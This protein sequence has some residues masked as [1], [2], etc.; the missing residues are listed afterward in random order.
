M[1]QRGSGTRPWVSSG[2]GAKCVWGTQ[3]RVGDPACP[4]NPNLTCLPSNAWEDV[5]LPLLPKCASAASLISIC[6]KN[7]GEGY[8]HLLFYLR[9][10][11]QIDPEEFED[12]WGRYTSHCLMCSLCSVQLSATLVL[13]EQIEVP[14]PVPV[15]W[16]TVATCPTI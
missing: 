11:T 16:C 10:Q 5:I 13:L 7:N 8:C 14:Y 9:Q 3:A 2:E 6:A 15:S 1:G 4:V 12:V